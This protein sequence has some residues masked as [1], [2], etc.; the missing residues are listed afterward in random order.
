MSIEM[1]GLEDAIKI[2][3]NDIQK[4]SEIN[5]H[6]ESPQPVTIS[7]QT[8]SIQIYRIV[9]ECIN[10]TLKHA[11]A[12]NIRVHLKNTDYFELTV[13]DDGKG[14]NVKDKIN[15]NS[16]G[17]RILRYRADVI[18]CKL[19]IESSGEGTVIRCNRRFETFN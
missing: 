15:N 11:D 3:V 2:L 5:C 6:F 9:Q 16:L 19:D 18:G 7:D 14:F 13:S 4:S 12:K 17:L 1:L 8:I 10:N